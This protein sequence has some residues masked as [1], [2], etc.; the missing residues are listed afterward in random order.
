MSTMSAPGSGSSGATFS[1]APTRL[2]L[3]GGVLVAQCRGMGPVSEPVHQLAERGAGDCSPSR[4]G[5]AK[6]V[7]M[8]AGHPDRVAPFGPPRAELGPEKRMALWTREQ[9]GVRLG[10][11]VLGQMVLEY[12]DELGRSI[13]GT[14]AVGLG[15]LKDGLAAGL[16]RG[17][18]RNDHLE[19]QI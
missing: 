9:Q 8:Q 11:Y 10:A 6:V 12:W 4:A 5:A 3:I 19:L 18:F 1:S 14:A 15:R 2:Q 17:S 16:L 13:D 7:E